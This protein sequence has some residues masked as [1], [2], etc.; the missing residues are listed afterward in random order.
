MSASAQALYFHLG[1]AADDDGVVEAFMVMRTVKAMEDDFRV[2]VL[3]GFVKP[4][5]E[6]LVSYIL[7]W[8]EH[9]LIRS[10]RLI[11]SIYREL[12]VQVMPEIELTEPRERAD[13]K[14]LNG[15]PLDNQRTAQDRV[16]EDSID[17][18]NTSS[19]RSQ[20]LEVVEVSEEE[21]KPKSPAKYPNA[22]KVFSL[23][24]EYPKHWERNTTFLLA[25]EEF[26]ND[27]N[28]G[29]DEAEYI[30]KAWYPKNKDKEYCPQIFNPHDLLT[31]Y[32]KIE[33][34]SHKQHD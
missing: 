14:R 5:N 25:A 26:Y 33:A 15:R 21:K 34:F 12:L 24:G 20:I 32:P 6:E 31:K 10:D 2:L 17:K 28:L 8:N 3:K 4:L 7:D 23:F 18:V 13:I 16:G 1:M 19:L 27:P 9:N 11:P 30:M 29:F 22:K